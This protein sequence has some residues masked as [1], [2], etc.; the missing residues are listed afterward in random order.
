VGGPDGCS[1]T[2]GILMFGFV[3]YQLW[4]T[5][6][7]TAR[8]QRALENEFEQLLAGTVPS[9]TRRR[10]RRRRRSLLRPP[11]PP[12]PRW[13]ATTVPGTVR[14][15]APPTT[16]PPAVRPG[17]P[18]DR[19]RRPHRPPGDPLDRGPDIV[20]AGVSV[21]DLRK[22]P[23]A[24]PRDAVARPA[25]QRRHR[26]TPHHV[27]ATLPPRRRPPV[28]GD[29]IIVTTLAGRFVYA[30]TGT[31]IVGPPTATTWCSPPNRR[32]ATITLTSCHPAY[33]ARERIVVRGVLDPTRSD[34]VGYPTPY[35]PGSQPP[36]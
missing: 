24:L 30:V 13:P 7:E 6:I 11:S 9:T 5:G 4:G 32:G 25:R 36:S 28:P 15:T 20:V 1:L 31:E 8:A 35:A 33:S 26:R 17:D 2:V 10:P 27:R 16:E 21:E 22:G 23:R 12:P 19:R 34:P 3:A 14:A 18:A 29:D